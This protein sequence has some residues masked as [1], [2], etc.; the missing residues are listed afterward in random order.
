MKKAV[1]VGLLCFILAGGYQAACA[2]ISIGYETLTIL[3]NALVLY[4]NDPESGWGLKASADFGTSFISGLTSIIG[5][6]ATFGLT[7]PKFSF[8][9]L[10]FTKDI[11]RNVNVRDYIRLGAFF[12]T[13]N[14]GNTSITKTLPTIGIGR[15]ISK[16]FNDRLVGNA[17]LSYPEILTLN[18]RYSF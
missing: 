3:P 18:L 6:V 9:T 16:L 7:D 14:A 13:A 5:K 10:S 12:I 11:N 17:E 1:I 8:A 2:D 4:L 15:D